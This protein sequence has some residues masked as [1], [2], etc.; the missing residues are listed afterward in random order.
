MEKHSVKILDK[1][2]VTHDVRSFVVEKPANYTFT[3]GQA[4]EVALETEGWQ[5]E[6]RPFTFTNLIDDDF[7]QFIIKIYPEHEGVTRQLD[8]LKTGDRL[9][10]HEIFGAI[11]Y[12]G[13]GTFIAG[14]TGITPFIAIFRNLRKENK[15]AGNQLIFANKTEKDI[16]LHKELDELFE[17]DLINIL[18]DEK[19]SAYHH[20]QVTRD[21]LSEHIANKKG[22]IYLCGPPPMMESVLKSLSEL[23]IKDE[24]II[25]E[26]MQ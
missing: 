10:L 17:D 3:P 12:K 20:G 14:G 26:E 19:K 23:G 8:S 22:M 16:I 6:K 11:S 2:L 25:T 24:A 5:D 1:F 15:L 18:S 4:T 9:I 21:F 7:L 13:T